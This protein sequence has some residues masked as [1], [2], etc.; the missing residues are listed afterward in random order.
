MA[1]GGRGGPIG[2]S[3]ALLSSLGPVAPGFKAVGKELVEEGGYNLDSPGT[4]AR[5]MKITEK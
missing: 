3:S 1:G 2:P 5:S 4:T